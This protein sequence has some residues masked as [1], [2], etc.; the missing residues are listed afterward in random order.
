MRIYTIYHVVGKT[1]GCTSNFTK[2]HRQRRAHYG[3]DIVMEVLDI[4]PKTLGEK[5]AGDVEQY[6]MWYYW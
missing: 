3:N 4:I 6:Y 1:I 5:F 2:R